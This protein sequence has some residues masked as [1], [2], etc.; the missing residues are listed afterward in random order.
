MAVNCFGYSVVMV[1]A[2]GEGHYIYITIFAPFLEAKGQGQEI[3][4]F[5]FF[6]NRFFHSSEKR[7]SIS[8]CVESSLR[9]TG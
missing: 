4:I 9:V 7:G 6:R 3:I 2:G 1:N 8:L 5:V